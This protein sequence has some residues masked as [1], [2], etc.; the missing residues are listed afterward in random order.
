MVEYDSTNKD[1]KWLYQRLI[2][3]ILSNVDVTTLE[4]SI[5]KSVDKPVSYR[6]LGASQAII[7]FMDHIALKKEQE[8]NEFSYFEISIQ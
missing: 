7:T 4:V 2:R 6:F 3:N 1:K 8:N 5:L